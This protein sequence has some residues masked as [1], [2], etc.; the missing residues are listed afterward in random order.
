MNIRTVE[1]RETTAIA[2]LA[3]INTKHAACSFHVRGPPVA[4][5]DPSADLVVIGCLRYRIS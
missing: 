3:K 4:A 2:W 5:F 1:Q